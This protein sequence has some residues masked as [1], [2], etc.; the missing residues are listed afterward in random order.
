VRIP[1][2][3]PSRREIRPSRVLGSTSGKWSAVI[4]SIRSIQAEGRPLLVGTVSV[5]ASE[6]LSSLL[7]EQGL[8]HQVLNARQ[9]ADEARI[10]SQAGQ[11]GRIT[12]A[13][14]MAG[15]G[16]DIELGPGVSERGGL[17][18]IATEQAE[19]RRI[20]RQL[21]G[22]CGRQG[23]PG[24]CETILSLD[25][26][27]IASFFPRAIRRFFTGIGGGQDIFFHSL[28]VFLLPLPRIAEERKHRR[29]RRALMELEEYLEDLLAYSG[30]GA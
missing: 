17:H 18:V 25:D 15:R 8:D 20:D 29:M 22:R 10:V 6:R 11:A 13:T 28:V 2:R 21:I 3:L 30:P 12:V 16:T 24:T 1:T 27:G 9:D 5:E 7:T 4:E 14:S 26:E 19:A 23:D